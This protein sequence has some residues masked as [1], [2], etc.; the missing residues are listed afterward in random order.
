ME[1]SGLDDEILQESVQESAFHFKD[2][3]KPVWV[4]KQGMDGIDF[5]ANLM[6]KAIISFPFGLLLLYFKISLRNLH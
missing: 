2:Y 5:I 3:G 1:A 6:S 4:Y